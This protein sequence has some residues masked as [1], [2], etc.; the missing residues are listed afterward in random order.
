[1]AGAFV[2]AVAAGASAPAEAED[3]GGLVFRFP[4]EAQKGRVMPGGWAKE[5]SVREFPISTGLAGVSMLLE[6][7]ALRE[8]HWHAIAAEWGYV[9][10]GRCRTTAYDPDGTA[11]IDDFN[12]GD[13]WNFPRGHGHSI[14]ALGNEPCHFILIFDNGTFSEFSTFSVSDW[15]AHV[16][17]ELLARN[18]GVS[19]KDLGTLPNGE[20]YIAPGP[21]LDG[22]IPELKARRSPHSH[23]YALL[24]ETPAIFP[25]GRIHLVTRKKFP[26]STTLSGGVM[27]VDPQGFREMHWH[28]NADEWQYVL[29]GRMRMTVFESRGKA[30][31]VELGPGDVGYVPMGMGH[32]LENMGQ[33]VLN[34]LLVFNSGDYQEISLAEWL[35]GNPASLVAQNLSLPLDVVK[36]FP[37]KGMFM[38]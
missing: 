14:Q 16:P 18:L 38:P 27:T 17:R 33:D 8:L 10:S 5:A 13:V 28:P 30:S 6:P 31:T 23:R 7:G 15:V 20:V 37:Q 22:P 36:K 25:G 32:Y 29:S 34:V 11:E 26:L 12:P 19:E 3:S 21:V 35:A 9:V 4:L 1:M 24:E 2:G